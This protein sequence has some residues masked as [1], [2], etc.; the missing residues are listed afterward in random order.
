M[1]RYLYT[2]RILKSLYIR[3]INSLLNYSKSN[4]LIYTPDPQ[5]I[6]KIQGTYS[7]ADVKTEL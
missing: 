6:L 3:G 7:N 2:Q 4:N 1:R 5:S